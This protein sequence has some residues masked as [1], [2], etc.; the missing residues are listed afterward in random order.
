M[1]FNSTF[2]FDLVVGQMAEKKLAEVLQG[3]RIEVKSDKVAHKTG[4]VFVEYESRG[5]KSGL[6]TT[7]ADYYCFEVSGVFILISTPALK[8]ICRKYIGTEHDIRGGDS[9]TSKGI[10]LPLLELLKG[11]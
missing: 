9:N 1:E 10:L 7:Q 2:A 5:K 3:K 6:A 11:L 8:A 4:R